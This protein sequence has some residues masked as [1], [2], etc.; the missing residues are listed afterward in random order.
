MDNVKRQCRKLVFNTVYEK[1]SV[2]VL[3]GQ[4]PEFHCEYFEKRRNAFNV[5]RIIEGALSSCFTSI[6]DIGGVYVVCGPGSFTGIKLGLSVVFG[7]LCGVSGRLSADG[8]SL[9]DY[10]IHGACRP[11]LA[12][13]KVLA[14]VPGVRN[15]YFCKYATVSR[16]GLKDTF[17]SAS[18]EFVTSSEKIAGEIVP[19]AIICE[20]SSKAVF[21][22]ALLS[23]KF[24]GRIVP[25]AFSGEGI[26]SFVGYCEETDGARILPLGPI[27]LKDT[28]VHKPKTEIA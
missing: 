19:D 7:I 25:V 6:D 14:V 17:A 10:L 8:L 26:A 12:G 16:S 4:K 20:P 21:E 24:G 2:T 13:K 11:E 23:E 22:D 28:Y 27:Y 3:N 5:D 1:M 15:E 9:L 18:C